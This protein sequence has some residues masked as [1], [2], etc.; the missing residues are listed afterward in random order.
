MNRRDAL[1][2]M[3][4]AFAA[5]GVTVT[6]VTEQDASEAVCAVLKANRPLSNQQFALINE[7]WLK[8]VQGTTLEKCRLLVLDEGLQLEFVKLKA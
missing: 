5:A 6:P 1:K 4:S 3:A 8:A 7:A 2:S